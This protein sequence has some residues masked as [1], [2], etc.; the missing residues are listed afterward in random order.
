M[1]TLVLLQD[2]SRHA[3]RVHPEQAKALYP[4]TTAELAS[5]FNSQ[6]G[7]NQRLDALPL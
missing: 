2:G 5:V 6:L 4:A 1:F 7:H 3:L